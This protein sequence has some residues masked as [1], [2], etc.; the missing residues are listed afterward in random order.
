VFERRQ[1]GKIGAE[2]IF[3]TLAPNGLNAL[4]W[5]FF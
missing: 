2:G 1:R 3:L 5:A 4:R